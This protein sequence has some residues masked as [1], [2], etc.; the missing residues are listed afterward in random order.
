MAVS[1]VAI[2]NLALQKIGA[3]RIASLSDADENARACNACYELLRDR[4]LRSNRWK[5]AI[6]RA[7]LAPHSTTPDFTYLYAFL[8]PSDCLRVLF[9]ARTALDWKIE[10]HEGDP[11]ILTND[12][13]TLEIRYVARVT[14]PT[15]FDALFVES[16]ACK[17][18]WHL[19][20]AITQSNTKKDSVLNE[21]KMAI[22]EARRM[23][24]IELGVLK[25]PVDEWLTARQSGQLYNSE[26]GEE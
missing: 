21:Y 10:N 8:L 15:K 2:C 20:E 17:I 14:D 18:A 19:C 23:N 24:A 9:P 25:Q 12:G 22:A 11:A 26:W 16:F 13:D 5:F 7:T 6:K 3:A 4:E 1:D